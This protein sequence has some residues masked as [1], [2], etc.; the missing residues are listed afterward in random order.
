MLENRHA[1]CEALMDERK[2]SMPIV[3]THTD[4]LDLETVITLAPSLTDFV[5]FLE[6]GDWNDYWPRAYREQQ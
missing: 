4:D 3:V 5:R 1:V 2:E 6:T